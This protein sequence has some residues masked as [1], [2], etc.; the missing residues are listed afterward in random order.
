VLVTVKPAVN[1]APIANAGTDFSVTLPSP[2]IQLNGSASSDPDGTITTWSW[3]RISGP[4]TV[5]ITAAGTKLAT[6]LGAIAGVHQFE[7]VVTDNKGAI[8]KDTVKVTVNNAPNKAPFAKAGEDTTIYVPANTVILNGTA[9]FDADGVITSAKWTQVEGPR[10]AVL[11]TP[12]SVATN[13]SGLYT[14]TYLFELMVIDNK[15]AIGKDTIR[16]SVVNNFKHT[17]ELALYPNPT[18]GMLK[19]R[20]ISDTQGDAIASIYN[21]SG[22]LVKT[23]NIARSQSVVIKEISVAELA[24]GVYYLHVNLNN[25]KKMVSKFVKQ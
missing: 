14:G 1:K 13:A 3:K 25:Q 18:R 6:V 16:V 4:G 22:H 19:I 24:P 23:F 5:N 7:L 12:N 21:M 8:S 11:S 9:S 15:G 2:V 10:E 17:E 20:C